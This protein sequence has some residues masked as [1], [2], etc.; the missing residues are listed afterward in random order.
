[1]GT[2]FPDYD[3][4]VLFHAA[5]LLKQ[6]GADFRLEFIGDGPQSQQW[7]NFVT[8]NALGDNV[9]LAGYQ[10]GPE[11][12]RRLRHAHVLLFPL[13]PSDINACRCPGKLFYYT[14]ARRPVIATPVG[15]VREIL[16][17]HATYVDCSPEAFAD[18]IATRLNAP[19]LPDVDYKLGTWDDRAGEL[20]AAVRAKLPQIP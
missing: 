2:L 4:D 19:R 18:A 11:L 16:Q 9:G 13:R 3:H 10:T 8:D 17:D 15:E 20:L 5:R 6:R 7:R 14:H 1:M 12:Y